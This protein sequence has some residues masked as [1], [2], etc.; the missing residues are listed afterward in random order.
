M[1]ATGG[2]AIQLT[3]DPSDDFE[4]S[5]SPDGTQIVFWSDRGG[6]YDLWILSDLPD[7]S[8]PTSVATLPTEALLA[9]NLPNPFNPST[10]IRYRLPELG[11]VRLGIYDVRGHLVRTL[12]D[13][14]KS[15]GAFDA[16]WDGRNDRGR[17]VSSGVYVYQLRTGSFR[18]SKRMV[19][20]R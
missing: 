1:P 13:G 2:E 14:T 9:Q 3:A 8:N 7:F 20:T 19:L 15:A 12:V 6:N 11:Y 17:W 5:W 18:Q 10:T 4:P 16:T